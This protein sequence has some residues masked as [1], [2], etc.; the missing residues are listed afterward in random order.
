MKRKNTYCLNKVWPMFVW[1]V[2]LY[3]VGRNELY[4][5]VYKSIC[6]L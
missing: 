5:K 3:L 6:T 2:C 4:I 1:T